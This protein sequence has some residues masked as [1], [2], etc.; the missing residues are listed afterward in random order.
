[1][2][3]SRLVTRLHGACT[4][5]GLTPSSV[6]AM[7]CGRGWG[8]G[9]SQWN[10]LDLGV[11]QSTGT[12]AMVP[13]KG[14]RTVRRWCRRMG[15]RRVW[16]RVCG[17]VGLVQLDRSIGFGWIGSTTDSV[18][19]LK[20]ALSQ[21]I[22]WLELGFAQSSSHQEMVFRAEINDFCKEVQIQKSALTQ[23][24]TAFRLETQECLNTLRAQ[25]SEIIS[26]INR[27][28]DDKRGKTVLE[29]HS[30]KIEAVLVVVEEAA[31]NL[32]GKEV[33]LIEEAGVLDVAD[34]QIRPE[35]SKLQ[36]IEVFQFRSQHAIRKK[37]SDQTKIQI[38][39]TKHARCVCVSGAVRPLLA[40]RAPSCDPGPV[41]GAPAR[42]A[43][44]GRSK[45]KSGGWSRGLHG[46]VCVCCRVCGLDRPVQ[47]N[48]FGWFGWTES[49]VA[50][51]PLKVLNNKF[52]LYYLKKNQGSPH[53]GEVRKISGDK[54]EALSESKKEKP[55]KKNIAAGSSAAPAKSPKRTKL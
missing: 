54:A 49:S 38:K 29:V 34:D 45:A 43:G 42:V 23:E 30:L 40:A 53:A 51:H 41:G 6:S 24:L 12:P 35:V 18:D 21:Q 4:V 31:A 33:D 7:D 17:G 20:A 48:R 55:M 50:L 22:T 11:V 52:V 36:N 28:R 32:Q 9:W 1:M 46:G 39:R 5:S 2:A 44:A 15:R 14:R 3:R 37:N 25:L 13:E 26:Y 27:G 19:E 10:R 16:C 8:S 47:L